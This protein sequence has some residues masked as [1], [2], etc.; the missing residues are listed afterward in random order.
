MSPA[1]LSNLTIVVVEDHDDARRYLALFLGQLGA[2]VVIAKNADEGLEAI[3]KDQPDIVLTDIR[4]PGTDGF[5][6][7]RQVRAL[8]PHSGGSVPV[9]AMSA[10]F[11]RA[12]RLR[13]LNAGFQ[14]CLPKPF[15]PDKLVDAILEILNK[16]G[17]R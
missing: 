16:N 6:L 15:T 5:E 8:G 14:G 13:V 7:L 17:T 1:R 10:L 11:A 4:M 3:E 12:D 2:R 9:I